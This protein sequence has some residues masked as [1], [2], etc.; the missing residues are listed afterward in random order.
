MV[1]RVGFEWLS[2]LSSGFGGFGWLSVGF[3]AFYVFSGFCCF[4]CGGPYLSLGLKSMFSWWF[5]P[6]HPARPP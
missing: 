1:F 4:G 5:S 6:S 2:E 3:S